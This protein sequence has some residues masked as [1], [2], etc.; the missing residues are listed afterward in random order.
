M[1]APAPE[2]GM[3][4]RL[5]RA[6]RRV[7]DP[8]RDRDRERLARIDDRMA[9]VLDAAA[10]QGEWLAVLLRSVEAQ[11]QAGRVLDKRLR[12][13]EASLAGLDA[14]VERLDAGSERQYRAVAQALKQAGWDE[15]LRVDERRVLRRLRRLRVSDR[16]VLVGPWAGE[17]GFEL[18]YWIPFVTWAVR[19]A[20]ID[21]ARIVVVSRGGP[22]SWYSHLGGRYVDILDHVP[23][24]E[25]RRRTGDRRKQMA[26]GDFDRELVRRLIQTAGLGRP[27]LLHPGLMYRMF[28]PFWKQKTTVR[29]VE[30]YTRH[31]R[32]PRPSAPEIQG[33]LPAEYVAVRFYF[34]RCFPDTP[35][36]RAFAASTVRSLSEA[37]HVVLLGSGLR[38]DDH[39]DFEP[40]R[41]ARIHSLEDVMRPERNLDVQTAIVAGARA[42]VGTYGGYSYLAPLCGVPAIA[43]YS[44]RDGFFAHH[45]ELAERVFRRL[46]AGSLV[47]IDVRDAELVRLALAG[48][49]VVREGGSS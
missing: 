14:G 36:N 39:R 4:T 8:G 49:A 38:V 40:G 27:L 9:R 32:I 41:A 24:D 48:G 19:R 29:R 33:R 31:E 46:G 21:P 5:G 22:A 35:E 45:L 11:G 10:R 44:V 47:P 16:P 12:E 2:P 20:V 25:F 15:E 34:S 1:T 7:I 6:L 3:W 30:T 28:M 37:G 17:V 18:L 42:F 43:F 13:V 26:L 23:P